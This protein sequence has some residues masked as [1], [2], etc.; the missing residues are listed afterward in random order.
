M[1]NVPNEREKMQSKFSFSILFCAT[2]LA[3]MTLTTSAHAYIDPGSGSM[4]MTTILGVIAAVGYT[5]RKSFYRIKN[6]F[7]SNRSDKQT[8]DSGD[9]K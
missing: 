6:L 8:P 5:M 4:I 7:R 3:Y 1:E 2:L 9:D